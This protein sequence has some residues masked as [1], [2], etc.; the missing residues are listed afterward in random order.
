MSSLIKQDGG[1]V[2]A[3]NH[4]HA[5]QPVGEPISI[6]GVEIRQDAD[7]R[8]S[9]NDLHKAAGREP[10]H[11]PHN[12]L[13]L[14][15]T[16]ELV[17]EINH[18]SLMR[19]AF[20]VINGGTNRGTYVCKELVYAYAMWISPKFHLQV[21]RAYDQMVREDRLAVMR[22]EP[23]SSSKI[24]GELAL[25]ECYDRMLRPS[26]S[27]KLH[28]LQR[29]AENN[30]LDSSFL[31]NYTVD[32][33]TDNLSGTSLPTAPLT[34]LLKEKGIE[35]GP[36]AYNKLL[37][38]AGMLEKRRRNSSRSSTG[39]KDFWSVTTEGLIYGKNIT[40]PRSPRETQPHWYI[41]RFDE[42][43]RIVSSL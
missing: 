11:Q 4:I 39:Y 5:M 6:A 41:E 3:A 1:F 36:A 2:G 18:S 19:S 31:P 30:Q 24:A 25:L 16:Q 43:H 27:S 22:P 21:I 14:E 38:R 29:V 15:S 33:P 10:K 35:M 17:A 34:D 37:Q 42:L 40:T 8:F 20:Q 7:G 23:A 26:P 28:M 9:L 32:A 12:W 13:R